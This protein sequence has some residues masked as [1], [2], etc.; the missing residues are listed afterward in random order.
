MEYK[1]IIK[2]VDK[3]TKELGLPKVGKPEKEPSFP[4]NVPDLSGEDLTQLMGE[5]E[6]WASFLRAKV[7]ELSAKEAIEAEYRKRIFLKTKIKFREEGFTATDS[8]DKAV[9]GEDVEKVDKYLAELKYERDL[10]TPTMETYE[11]FVKVLSR[12]LTR[13]VGEH[14]MPKNSRKGGDIY[15]G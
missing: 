3:K 8:S 2:D 14:E 13:K 10:L 4:S 15:G 9:L 6:A 12:E 7:S 11:N 5:Y 1:D